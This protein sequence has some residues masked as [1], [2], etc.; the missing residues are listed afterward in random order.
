MLR[1]DYFAIKSETKNKKNEDSNR[2]TMRTGCHARLRVAYDFIEKIWKVTNFEPN[3]NHEP[4]PPNLV[5]LIPNYRKLSESD[6]QIVSGLHSQGVRTCHI[7]GFLMGQK[8]GHENL[9]FIKKDLYNF[10]DHEGRVRI[11]GGDTFATLSYFQ[12][13]ADNDS[14]FFFQSLPLQMIDG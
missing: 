2:Q 13:K 9:G 5:H 4:S 10:T 8:G 3:H 1:G 12:G 14:T 6:K 11:E 7:L